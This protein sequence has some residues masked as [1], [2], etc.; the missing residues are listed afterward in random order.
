[1]NKYILVVLSVTGGL[2]SSLAWSGWCSGLILLISFIPFFLIE[3]YLFR[4]R[5][6]YSPNAFF[7]YILPGFLI[8]SI[9]TIGWI[10]VA[11]MVAA[12]CMVLVISF[13]MAF[14]IWLSHII[15]LQAGNIPGFISL[16][17][18]WLSYEYLSLNSDFFSPWI[19]LGNGLAK[20]TLFIQWYDITGSSGGSLWILISNL[21]LTVFLVKSFY[22][23]KRNKLSLFLWLAIVLLPSIYSLTKYYTIKS[24]KDLKSEVVIVQPDIDPYK[25]K[26]KISFEQQLKKALEMSE[27]AISEKTDWVITPETTVDDPVDENNTDNNKYIKMV[28]EFVRKH[29][30]ISVVTGMT[31]IRYYEPLMVTRA[32]IFMKGDN[33]DNYYNQFN[34]AFKIDTGQNVSIYHK[35]KLVPGFEKQFSFIPG[36]IIKRLVPYL[37]GTQWSYRTQKERDVFEHPATRMK[38]APLICYE[39]V[40]GKFVTGYVK[41]G[42]NALFIITNDGWWKNTNGYKQHLSFASL[43]AIETRRPVARSAN[44]GISCII[45]IRGKIINESKWWTPAIMKGVIYPENTITTYV[46]YGDYILVI[47]TL[48]TI[49]VIVYVLNLF[50]IRRKN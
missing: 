45:D 11:S 40:Y 17:S 28:K 3:D 48:I 47:S 34:S 10:R 41:K 29:P 19:N 21:L 26:F 15:R 44:T 23:E 24:N 42:A 16:V 7:I 8:F 9:L 49:L 37:G 33:S 4:R 39:S 35:S 5:D 50:L 6:M 2:L 36:K 13:L 30:E 22:G 18:F 27:S 14:V 1:M 25:E 20:D 38:V 32:K 43:R 46:K 31:S 12:I